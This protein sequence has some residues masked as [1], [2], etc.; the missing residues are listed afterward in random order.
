MRF[1]AVAPPIPLPTNAE[2][3]VKYFGSTYNE[4]PS[5]GIAIPQQESVVLKCSLTDQ[6]MQGTLGTNPGLN[7]GETWLIGYVLEPLP[8]PDDCKIY[9]THP[10]TFTNGSSGIVQR[11]EFSFSES[12]TPFTTVLES[13]GIPISGY[14]KVIS[15]A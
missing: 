6:D 10:M 15:G 11:G 2:I 3:T 5:T 12:P 8:L 9:G 7:V 1:P 13:I 4:D 14:F